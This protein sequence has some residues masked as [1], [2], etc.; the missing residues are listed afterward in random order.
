MQRNPYSLMFGKTPNEMITR[1]VPEDEILQNF[2]DENP[3]QQIYMITGVRGVGKTV[4]MTN[5]SNR[6]KQDKSWICVELNQER[7]MLQSL[8]VKLSS[9]DTL[10]RIFKNSKI[11]LSFWGVGLEVT[12]AVQIADEEEAVIRILRSLKKH[13]KKLLITIDEASNTKSMIEFARSFQI[14]VRENLPIYLL[15]TGLYENIYELQNEK[16]LTFLYRAP[17]IELASLN[18]GAITNNY[19]HNFQCTENAALE[20]AMYTSG[21]S[22]AFQVLGYLTW[23][24]HGNY[25]EIIPQYRQ[26]LEEYVYEKIW[27]ELSDMD[28]KLCHA[29]ASSV[30]GRII[31]IRESAGIT[32]NQFNPYRKRLLKKGLAVSNTYGYLHFALPM[33]KEFVLE[34]YQDI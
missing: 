9:Y 13:E 19:R 17:K 25:R 26:Y 28:K 7:N 32:S 20:M 15:M 6:L 3:Q 2:L 27:T 11:N 5:I 30:D 21:Y 24:N 29:I 34:N 8:I 12:N 31:S 22:F 18:I 33:F 4:F 1:I 10:A 14:F 16:N 23:K